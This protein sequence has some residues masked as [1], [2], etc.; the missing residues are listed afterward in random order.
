MP[1]PL[2]PVLGWLVRQSRAPARRPHAG[3]VLVDD[4]L[5]VLAE[6]A[7]PQPSC[8]RPHRVHHARPAVA[9]EGRSGTP[10]R[11]ARGSARPGPRSH[12]CQR[13]SHR[14]RTGTLLPTMAGAARTEPTMTDSPWEGI[15]RVAAKAAL[16]V[17]GVC[18]LRPAL[19]DRLALA[20]SRA[21]RRNHIGHTAPRCG[22][23]S[24]RTHLGRWLPRGS[25]M[26]TAH[27][28]PDRGHRAAGTQLREESRHRPCCPASN[29]RTGD[30]PGHGHSNRLNQ[31]RRS[32]RARGTRRTE[33]L[34]VGDTV[35]GRWSPP[36]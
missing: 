35:A 32:R 17:P 23:H 14:R 1:H 19:C 28:P 22:Q 33:K 34:G 26:H 27:R 6:L 11:P 13:R 24:L 3:H 25:T 5:L 9:R 29:N 18:A 7:V 12:R 4:R 30:R 2:G 36:S 10:S 31:G 16:G 20:A 8:R 21:S 15:A